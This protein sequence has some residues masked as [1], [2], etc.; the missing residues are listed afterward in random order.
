MD[1]LPLRD[2]AAAACACRAW[3]AEAAQ[4]DRWGRFW[5]AAVGEQA[6][7]GWAKAGGGWREQLRARTAIRKGAALGWGR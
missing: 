7:W 3:R 5:R 4:D 2:L 6:L 1:L